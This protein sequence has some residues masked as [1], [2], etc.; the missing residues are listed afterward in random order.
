MSQG[1]VVGIGTNKLSRGKLRGFLI[2]HSYT[3]TLA[4]TLLAYAFPISIIKRVYVFV[5][6]ES[7][8]T[9]SS[10]YIPIVTMDHQLLSF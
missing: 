1:H 2:T 9:L 8:E 6:Q 7:D 3:C 4:Q 10:P 5:L